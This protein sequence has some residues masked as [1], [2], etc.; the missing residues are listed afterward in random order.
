MTNEDRLNQLRQEREQERFAKQHKLAT[1]KLWKSCRYFYDKLRHNQVVGIQFPCY[2]R[3]HKKLQWGVVRQLGDDKYIFGHN[4]DFKVVNEVVSLDEEDGD[5]LH[6]HS[7][8]YTYPIENSKKLRYIGN[9]YM[10]QIKA[11]DILGV[12]PKDLGKYCKMS[13][14]SLYKLLDE[15]TDDNLDVQKIFTIK[16]ALILKSNL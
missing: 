16:A 9:V 10:N 6:T 4:F 11:I 7:E 14:G 1:D 12:S 13:K 8:L 2:S 15:M 5:L 3:P